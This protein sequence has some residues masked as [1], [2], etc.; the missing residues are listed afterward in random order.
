MSNGNSP[1]VEGKKVIIHHA[2]QPPTSRQNFGHRSS[3]INAAHHSPSSKDSTDM[4]LGYL[5]HR[6]LTFFTAPGFLSE[7][8]EVSFSTLVSQYSIHTARVE[9]L[10]ASPHAFPPICMACR[11]RASLIPAWRRTRGALV[12]STVTLCCEHACNI[13]TRPRRLFGLLGVLCWS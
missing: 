4:R 8:F 12:H 7:F 1:N 11:R 10:A 13:L 9:K 3:R 5:P 6:A 2:E